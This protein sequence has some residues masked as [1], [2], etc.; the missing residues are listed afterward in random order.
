MLGLHACWYGRRT[1]HGMYADSLSS[2]S[3]PLLGPPWGLET[4]SFQKKRSTL[5]NTLMNWPAGYLSDLKRSLTTPPKS[6]FS[7]SVCVSVCVIDFREPHFKGQ[8]AGSGNRNSVSFLNFLWELGTK[9][10]KE[11]HGLCG[12]QCLTT[13]WGADGGSGWTCRAGLK[14]LWS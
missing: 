11:V 5:K 4:F 2:L 7:F 1:L 10:L 12:P 6:S 13:F 3:Q 9:Y 8:M 14:F